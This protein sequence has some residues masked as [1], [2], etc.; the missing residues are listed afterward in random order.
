MHT[1]NPI[2]SPTL[3]PSVWSLERRQ[4]AEV[5][6]SLS[7]HGSNS[8]GAD[9]DSFKEAADT[10]CDHKQMKL[11]VQQTLG[12]IDDMIAIPTTTDK[13]IRGGGAYENIWIPRSHVTSL[14]SAREYPI[15]RDSPC[16]AGLHS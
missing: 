11:T 12:L 3:D 15:I 1:K 9:S 2:L 14:L 5:S 6:S 4:P 16:N 7:D 10:G 13:T 8:R